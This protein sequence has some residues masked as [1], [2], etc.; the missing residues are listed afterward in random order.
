[1]YGTDSSAALRT[2]SCS[3]LESF[4]YSSLDIS[5]ASG[6]YECSDCDQYRAT[7]KWRL[8][9]K[10]VQLFSAPSM[11]FVCS[12]EKIS[13]YDNGV[14]FAPS[15]RTRLTNMSDGGTRILRPFRSPGSLT[16]RRW[17]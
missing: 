2:N 8:V 12:A 4:S 9:W 10:V 16:A 17:L 13:P 6:E 11:S 15:L 3:R 1:M 14:G 7:S 5:T